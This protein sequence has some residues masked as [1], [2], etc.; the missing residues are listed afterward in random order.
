MTSATVVVTLCALLNLGFGQTPQATSL[1]PTE[2]EAFARRPDARVTWS[3]EVWR[4]ESSE[5]RVVI[6]AIVIEDATALPQRMRG[7]RIDLANKTASDQ[8]YLDWTRLEVTRKAL[9]EISSGIARFRREPADSPYRY[10]GA[11]EFWRPYQAIHTLNA[12]YYIA[13]DS[14]GLS[15][16]AYKGQGFR[17]PGRSPSELAAAIS[18]AID[19]LKPR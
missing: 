13:P 4:A 18:R 14:S 8:V 12:S 6:T 10:L 7:I 3:S 2:L 5:A 15:L 19:E 16:S 11:E 1:K 9:R 17:F